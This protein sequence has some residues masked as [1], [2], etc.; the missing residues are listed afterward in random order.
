VN[1]NR[2]GRVVWL[3]NDSTRSEVLRTR[4]PLIMGCT[5]CVPGGDALEDYTHIMNGLI[6]V[7]QVSSARGV[8]TGSRLCR[9]PRPSPGN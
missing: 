6:K 5:S 2:I 3:E 4:T 1:V 8:H 9:L 7:D